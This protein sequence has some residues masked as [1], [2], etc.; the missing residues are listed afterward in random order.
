[1]EGDGTMIEQNSLCLVT[2]WDIFI[3]KKM[4]KGWKKMLEVP[5]WGLS[6]SN[7]FLPLKSGD[8]SFDVLTGQTSP[9]K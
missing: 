3:D 2:D 1:M 6:W 9:C 4:E 5:V 8:F 7:Q